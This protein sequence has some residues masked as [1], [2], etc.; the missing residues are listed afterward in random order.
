MKQILSLYLLALAASATLF[1]TACEDT[2]TERP[3]S[4]YERED[5]FTT[6]EKADM[7]VVGIYNV[8]PTLYASI[9]GM[10]IPCSDDIYYVYGTGSDNTRRDLA[11]YILRP[12]NQW[13]NE[14]WKGK[15]NCLNRANYTIAGI[16][17]MKGYSK[18]AQL[19]AMVA[20]AK[21]LRAQAAFDLVRYWG[22]VPFKTTYS[23]SYEDAYQ[24]RT[25]REDIYNQILEDLNFAKEKMPWASAST[26]PER[27]SQGAARALLMRV[28]LARAGYSLQLNGTLTRPDES[29]RQTYFK[30]AIQEWEA[31]QKEQSYHG[32]YGNGADEA[33]G[34]NETAPETNKG[35][36]TGLFQ[37]FSAGKINS[38]E[39][40]FEIAF[41]Y[42][43]TNGCWG[44][45][46]GGL[47]DAP[48]ASADANSVMGRAA[49][50]F[51][52]VPEWKK[53]FDE[54]DE[55][56]DIS[57]CTYTWKWD[58]ALQTHQK[59]G[60][61]S[62]TNWTPG[63]WRREWMPL[64]YKE[65][66]YTDVNFCLLRYAD[67]VLMAAEAYNE[68]G[69]TPRAWELLN[70][71]R[72]RAG[73]TEITTTNYATLLKE[74]KV[75]NLSFI[76]DTD[77]SGRFRTALYWERGFELAFEGQRKYDLIRWGIMKEAVQ[78]FGERTEINTSTR[79]NYLAGINF[80]K[81]KHELLPIPEDE[82]QVN[83]K[84]EKK[85]NP[86]Y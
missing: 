25:N 76:D 73:A 16:E 65:P 33:T 52:V 46:I 80:Q 14:V 77:E 15:Y 43:G 62:T 9:D 59:S 64:G 82:L 78:L 63:K 42:P 5:Y 24:P 53:F 58:A 56:R 32:F 7:A 20:E 67:V 85:N 79:N 72:R 31:F 69:N 30:A 36:Y 13:V 45:Y 50:N 48:G 37:G 35:S 22:D 12:S 61:T 29:L 19:Q 10:T 26:S 84:L 60:I 27:A 34:T 41:Y 57:I 2:L 86:G 8:L 55:R 66:N 39:S 18:D 38:R 28:L 40:L 17:G 68:T 83:Y 75:F 54:T 21:F 6:A 4:Y 71:V 74:P 11:H 51:R 47:V 3:D 81:G 49:V 44:T 70:S 23:S 1:C